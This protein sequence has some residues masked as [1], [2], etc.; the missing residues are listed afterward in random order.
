MKNE[1]GPVTKK[2]YISV[3]VLLK[4]DQLDPDLVSKEL[5]IPADTSRRKGEVRCGKQPGAKPYTAKTG[6]WRT[7][8]RDHGNGD[9][10][11][12][13]VHRIVGEVLLEFQK[14]QEPLSQI[15][16]VEQAFLDIFICETEKDISDSWTEFFVS[17]QQIQRVG[18]L[19]LALS[20]TTTLVVDD[21]ERS[22]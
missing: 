19:G 5:G 1:E 18:Q 16:G 9:R 4:G 3:S 10:T 12:N 11:W 20:I 8:S 14:R 6:V 7:K 13:E 15:P 17:S 2:P 22:R 21:D